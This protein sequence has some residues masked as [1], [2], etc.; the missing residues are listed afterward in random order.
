MGDS[1]ANIL[2]HALT[3]NLKVPDA[4]KILVP[5]FLPLSHQYE[6]SKRSGKW[7]KSA[8]K[9]LIIYRNITIKHPAPFIQ[10]VLTL[11]RFTEL[12]T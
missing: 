5:T 9:L 11:P 7:N 3:Y 8:G 4:N 10:S 1:E 6:S 12:C 2:L